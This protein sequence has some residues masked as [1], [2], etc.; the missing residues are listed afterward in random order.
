MLLIKTGDE[1]ELSAPIDF[2]SL[3][4]HSLPL[5][6]PD[7]ALQDESSPT[8]VRVPVSVAVP[9]LYGLQVKEE[10]SFPRRYTHI[11]INE[12]KRLNP[13]LFWKNGMM[14][15]PD[16]WLFYTD[17]E[18]EWIREVFEHEKYCDAGE[19]GRYA[20]AALKRVRKRNVGDDDRDDMGWTMEW[21]NKWVQR[22]F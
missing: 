2:T 18:D 19:H 14:P 1:A 4:S 13:S 16:E 17:S 7:L 15:S 6:R 12:N 9:F 8:A 5:G 22:I 3:T 20:Q 10:A 21:C 11:T